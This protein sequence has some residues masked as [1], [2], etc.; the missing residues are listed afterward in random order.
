M[1]YFLAAS[2]LP[3]CIFPHLT[4]A[5]KPTLCG[6]IKYNTGKYICIN[7]QKLCP[8]D[9]PDPCGHACF[10]AMGGKGR[11]FC[12][13]KGSILREMIAV[14]ISTSTATIKTPPVTV[15]VI[16]SVDGSASPT[17]HVGV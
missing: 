2:I 1:K 14:P 8:T 10:N 16:I 15:T 11:Y 3:F 7:D 17:A 12:D 13:P 5:I 6:G 4:T 9:A